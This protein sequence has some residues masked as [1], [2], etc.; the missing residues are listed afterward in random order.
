MG[1]MGF[2]VVCVLKKLQII[3]NFSLTNYKTLAIITKQVTCGR[4]GMADTQ[5]LGSCE[6]S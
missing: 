4:G 2:F 6:R 1:S 3:N 5:D